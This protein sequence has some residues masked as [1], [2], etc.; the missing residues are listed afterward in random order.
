MEET[1]RAFAVL[2]AL[3]LALAPVTNGVLE[4]AARTA[5]RV[6]FEPADWEGQPP[7]DPPNVT[8]PEDVP[9]G[10]ES[11]EGPQGAQ[12]SCEIE[13]EP[14][15]AWNH[16]A[17]PEDRATPPNRTRDAATRTS[18]TFEVNDT[19]L[20][21]GVALQITNLTGE[22]SA[23]LESPEGVEE[24]SYDHPAFS[25]QQDQVN[26]TTTISGDGLVTGEWTAEVSFQTA[27][28]DRL[29]YVVVTASCAEAE[30]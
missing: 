24:F 7:E 4:K 8:P 19:H 11:F 6:I 1:S 16:P 15:A 9:E 20:G 17:D 29:T 26:Q 27:N 28:Y 21:L 22:L 13:T 3:V 25:G 5:D 14:A 30:G 12:P 18:E 2:A 23:S 10:N